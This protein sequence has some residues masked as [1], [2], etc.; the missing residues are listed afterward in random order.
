MY[1]CPFSISIKQ[2]IIMDT[3]KGYQKKYLRELAHKLKPVVFV[4]QKGVT[5]TLLQSIDASLHAHELIKIKFIDHKE[6]DQKQS[7]LTQIEKSL[8]CGI[9]G[10]IGHVAIVY[11]EHPDPEKRK[12]TL[13]Q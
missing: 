7:L 8:G 1:K 11:R 3:L 4:G 13:P 6:K 2:E 9:A 12:I 5:D 10:L